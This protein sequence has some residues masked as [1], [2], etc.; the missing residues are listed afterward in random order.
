[1][2]HH[3]LLVFVCFVEKGFHH[4]AQAALLTLI[5]AKMSTLWSVRFYWAQAALRPHKVPGFT[6]TS[7]CIGPCITPV[8]SAKL[9]DSS[10]VG[11]VPNDIPIYFLTLI[12]SLSSFTC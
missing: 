11:E 6:D 7:H 9:A 5:E 4:V 2:N 8:T 12:L 3:T 1:M 10:S